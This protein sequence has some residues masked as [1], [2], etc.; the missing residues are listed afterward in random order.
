MATRNC[1]ACQQ[2]IEVHEALVGRVARCRGCQRRFAITNNPDHGVGEEALDLALAPC[3]GCGTA[4]AA[5]DQFCTGCGT[6][7]TAPTS[8]VVARQRETE[9][10]SLRRRT[11]VQRMKHSD[12]DRTVRRASDWILWVGALFCVFGLIYGTISS[13]NAN[14]ARQMLDREYDSDDILEL[15]DG[16]L[17]T[18]QE[19]KASADLEVMVA[20]GV[21]LGLGAIFFALYFWS[22]RAPLPAAIMALCIYLVVQAGQAILDPTTLYQGLLFKV[23]FVIALGAGIQAALQQQAAQRAEEQRLERAEQRKRATTAQ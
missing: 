4:A 10:R 21:N 12:L 18:V 22:K 3:A 19:L 6:S 17:T 1:P 14:E 2:T 20:F 13:K 5:A 9:Q 7:L 15:E 23:F 16:S 8:E 11:A